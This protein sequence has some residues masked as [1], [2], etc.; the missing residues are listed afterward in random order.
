[1]SETRCQKV[2]A[3]DLILLGCSF[4]QSS[5]LKPLPPPMNGLPPS[6]HADFSKSCNTSH[7]CDTY[8]SS[9]N[10]FLFILVLIGI[11][12][13]KFANK[14]KTSYTNFLSIFQSY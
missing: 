1:M 9:I 10:S 2:A 7:L 13:F 8:I 11:A 6:R 5:F 12:H 3:L 4:C 14:F